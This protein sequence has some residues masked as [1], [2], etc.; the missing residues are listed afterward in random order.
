MTGCDDFPNNYNNEN[1]VDLTFKELT[2][3]GSQAAVVLCTEGPL[4]SP[5]CISERFVCNDGRWIK[6]LPFTSHGKCCFC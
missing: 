5:D 2:A 3:D 1:E 6:S 4:A